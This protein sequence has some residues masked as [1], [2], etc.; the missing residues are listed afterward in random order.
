MTMIRRFV[1]SQPNAQCGRV[2]SCRYDNRKGKRNFRAVLS[3]A[4]INRIAL[5]IHENRW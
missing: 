3:P 1:F 5:S 4:A 2:A